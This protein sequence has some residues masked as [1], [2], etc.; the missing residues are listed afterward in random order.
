MVI[1]QA[2]LPIHEKADAAGA[3]QKQLSGFLQGCPQGVVL[4]ENVHRL[5]PQLLPV[6][7]N[8][9]SEQGSFEASTCRRC[10]V[11]LIVASLLLPTY[12]KDSRREEGIVC[13]FLR[14]NSCSASSACRCPG[15]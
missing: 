6:F 12:N 5:H 7:I 3:A 14:F 9:L 1:V 15:M 13:C 4:L 2:G 10:Q 11:S 8:A